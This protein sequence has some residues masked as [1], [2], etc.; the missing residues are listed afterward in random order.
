MNHI[1][2][3][4]KAVFL[5]INDHLFDFPNAVLY[6]AWVAGWRKCPD[7]TDI[8]MPQINGH[9]QHGPTAEASFNLTCHIIGRMSSH[10]FQNP[11]YKGHVFTRTNP[12]IV[13]HIK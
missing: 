6:T 8:Y 2:T 10:L 9:L 7:L 1:L 4:I 11:K 5:M 12:A 13:H 3:P